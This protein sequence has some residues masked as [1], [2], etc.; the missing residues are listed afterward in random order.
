VLQASAILPLLPDI[1][2]KKAQKA[3]KKSAE[4]DFVLFVPFCGW[5]ILVPFCG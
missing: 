2:H 4:N 5:F 1:S 3:H